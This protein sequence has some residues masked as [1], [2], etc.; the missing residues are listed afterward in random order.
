M[1]LT[2]TLPNTRDNKAFKSRMIANIK[3]LVVNDYASKLHSKDVLKRN[4][5]SQFTI[6][7]RS[8]IEDK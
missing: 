5:D 3:Q 7:E 1:L 4:N 6:L 2:L 8:K